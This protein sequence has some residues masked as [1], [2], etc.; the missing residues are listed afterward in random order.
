[1]KD[2]LFDSSH[3]RKKAWNISGSLPDLTVTTGVSGS[4]FITFRY[5]AAVSTAAAFSL[6]FACSPTHTKMAVY[7]SR[8]NTSSS[9]RSSCVKSKTRSI[10]IAP[11]AFDN[12]KSMGSREEGGSHLAVVYS[13][14][15]PSLDQK[16]SGS[17][18]SATSTIERLPPR[19]FAIDFAYPCS[20]SF[21]PEPFQMYIVPGVSNTKQS[22]ELS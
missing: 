17:E 21:E 2:V 16:S 10:L 22:P 13:A 7:T 14:L 15:P 11:D 6:S 20:V 8:M 4:S 1:M 19:T 12:E 5:S 9:S 3:P 18:P